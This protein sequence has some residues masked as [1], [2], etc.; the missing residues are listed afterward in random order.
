MASRTQ[1]RL[2]QITGSFGNSVGKIRDDIPAAQ[3]ATLAGIKA[4]DLTGSLG[5][6]A[7]AIKRINGGTAFSSQ[8]EGTNM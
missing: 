1:I 8:G 5:I 2:Q 7:S 4:T 3:G 6:I